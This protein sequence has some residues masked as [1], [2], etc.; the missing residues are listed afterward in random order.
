MKK[1]VFLTSV[2]FLVTFVSGY[3]IDST[4]DNLGHEFNIDGENNK[5]IV[6]GDGTARYGRVP[7]NIEVEN[8]SGFEVCASGGKQEYSF[9]LKSNGTVLE[10]GW[11]ES[12]CRSW[13]LNHSF[14]GDKMHVLVWSRN[15]DSN[16]THS[17][18]T[19]SDSFLQLRYE[20]VT[21][22]EAEDNRRERSETGDQ[23]NK[24]FLAELFRAISNLL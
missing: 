11:S 15:S 5:T 22:V 18:A 3:Q 4:S 19:R 16:Y 12:S 10:S 24:G 17:S 13:N 2:L 9:R 1:A 6:Y 20:N 7:M 14:M 23:G 21:V 8:G